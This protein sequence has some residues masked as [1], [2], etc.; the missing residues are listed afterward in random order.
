MRQSGIRLAY[1]DALN[2]TSQ[3]RSQED[4]TESLGSEAE[5]AEID[6]ANAHNDPHHVRH[7][8]DYLRQALMA[9]LPFSLAYS[10]RRQLQQRLTIVSVPQ[11]RTSSLLT[12]QS[13]DRLDGGLR[14]NAATMKVLW[15]GRRNGDTIR[16]VE[17]IDSS[18]V[19]NL[20]QR[21]S[22]D[23]VCYS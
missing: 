20:S 15:S 6:A 3:A 18:F 7:C 13:E 22:S 8:F 19:S 23:Y 2:R 16:R 4:G 10:W 9:C 17:L 1:Y 11:I 21:Q 14:D 5:D 12:G